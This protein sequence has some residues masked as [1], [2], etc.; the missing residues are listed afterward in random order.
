MEMDLRKAFYTFKDN[1]IKLQRDFPFSFGAIGRPNATH[2]SRPDVQGTGNG[3][4][5]LLSLV[6]AC[7]R[8]ASKH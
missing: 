3:L 8:R 7:I 1:K 2:Y 6:P 4:Q 5:T